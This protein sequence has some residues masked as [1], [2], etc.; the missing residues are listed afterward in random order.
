MSGSAAA[1][2]AGLRIVAGLGN[3]GARYERTRH[4]L[5]FRVVEEL[6]GRRGATF[7]REECGGLVAEQ[8]DVL[9][10]KPLTYMNRSGYTLRCLR[11]R[12][13]VAPAEMLVVYD[14]VRLP[15]GR[16]RVRRG[17]DPAGHRGMESIVNNLRTT[18]VPRLRLGVGP[19][20]AELPGQ[21]MSDYVLGEFEAEE[22]AVAR[23]M[24]TRAADA[25]E[26][27]LAHGVDQAMNLFNRPAEEPAEGR[28]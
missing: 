23:E 13:D 2:Q 15:L 7:D 27:W 16:L 10:V 25:V 26:A 24:V 3:P 9:L 1:D 6:A 20:D 4:N 18:D 12:R 21:V 11:E 5:G 22:E 19:T 14:E 8:E 28:G 17:G